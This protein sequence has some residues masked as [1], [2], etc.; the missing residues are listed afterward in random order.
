MKIEKN[1]V[2][3]E[4]LFLGYFIEDSFIHQFMLLLKLIHSLFPFQKYLFRTT[5]FVRTK[6]IN[7]ALICKFKLHYFLITYQMYF[8]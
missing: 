2:F 8:K 6:I 3:I 7:L 5:G 1:I 4:N